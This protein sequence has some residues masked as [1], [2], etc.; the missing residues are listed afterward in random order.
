MRYDYYF[1]KAKELLAHCKEDNTSQEWEK[2]CVE[3]FGTNTTLSGED[4]NKLVALAAGRDVESLSAAEKAIYLMLC[5]G[6]T[7][8]EVVTL[9]HSD[10]V[11]ED[12]GDD[13]VT[14]LCFSEEQNGIEVV[15]RCVPISLILYVMVTGLPGRNRKEENVYV[16]N[17][18]DT[19]VDVNQL[20]DDV[21]EIFEKTGVLNEDVLIHLA[22][23][24]LTEKEKLGDR[25]VDEKNLLEYLLRR[26]FA[27]EHKAAGFTEEQI[28]YMMGLSPDEDFRDLEETI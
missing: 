1:E 21:Y 20:A 8:E 9:R 25:A 22:A 4:A 3:V 23:L 17:M 18:S 2:R 24:N 12:A 7:M 27:T 14:Y 26:T 10:F 6:V 19:P 5:C 15:S 28:G 13:I 16:L 11:R